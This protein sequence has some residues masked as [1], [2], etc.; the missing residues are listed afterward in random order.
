M[1]VTDSVA[2]FVEPALLATSLL[3]LGNYSFIWY[4]SLPPNSI[5]NHR[6]EQCFVS[7][8]N[9]SRWLAMQFAV[10]ETIVVIPNSQSLDKR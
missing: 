9:V 4:K 2:L 5:G 10:S 1:V 7:S 3:N 8:D 6:I